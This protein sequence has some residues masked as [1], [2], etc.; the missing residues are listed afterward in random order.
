MRSA[1]EWM[2][3]GLN[4]SMGIKSQDDWVRAIQDDALEAAAA[5]LDEMDKDCPSQSSCIYPSWA[6][7]AVRKLRSKPPDAQA[8]LKAENEKL[9]ALV[10]D[11]L[12]FCWDL[13]SATLAR[14]RELGVK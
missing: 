14:A 13:P 2:A 9:R 5:M 1:E 4:E 7:D 12:P 8:D 6:A 11:L 10:A 3:I